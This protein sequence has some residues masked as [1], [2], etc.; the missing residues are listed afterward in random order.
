MRGTPSISNPL[1]YIS[2]IVSGWIN[3]VFLIAVVVT[4]S[5]RSRRFAQ[6]AA[7]VILLMMP[8]CWIVFYNHNLYPREGYVAWVAGMLTVL[9]SRSEFSA[10]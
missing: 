7:I 3:P 6:A 2:Y 8:T 9:W 10:K 4:W 1:D 5:N